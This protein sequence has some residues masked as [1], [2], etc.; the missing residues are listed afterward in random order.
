MCI[1]DSNKLV[2]EVMGLGEGED[3]VAK[4]NEEVAACGGSTQLIQEYE[5][6][7]GKKALVIA[8]LNADDTREAA[9]RAMKNDFRCM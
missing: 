4:F 7:N 5:L 6:A 2:A 9:R 1:R 8:G 3:C